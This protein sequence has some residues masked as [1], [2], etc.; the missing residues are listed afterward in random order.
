MGQAKQIVCGSSASKIIVGKQRQPTPKKTWELGSIVTSAEESPGKFHGNTNKRIMK[1]LREIVNGSIHLPQG[2]HIFI[3]NDNLTLMKAVI[4][5]PIGTPFEDGVFALNIQIP[6]DYPFRPPKIT[7][8]NP[9]YHCN[10]SD[11][12]EVCLDIL[13]TEWVPNLSILQAIEAILK[14]LSNPNSDNA[15]RQWIAEITIAHFQSDGKDTR[16]VDNAK[17]ATRKDA[18]RSIEDWK[19]HWGLV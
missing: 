18:V 7:F 19:Q 6:S 13:M 9:V 15:L 14:M 10:V 8:E 11:I 17:A 16:Y 1:E 2:V 12:G 4:Q 3:D 5:G